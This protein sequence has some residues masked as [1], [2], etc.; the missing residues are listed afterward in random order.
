MKFINIHTIPKGSILTESTQIPISFNYDS[1]MANFPTELEIA[2]SAFDSEE[3]IFKTVYRY[4]SEEDRYYLGEEKEV[5]DSRDDLNP[6][7][8]MSIDEILDS[9]SAESSQLQESEEKTDEDLESQKE[10]EIP[11][12]GAQF[13]LLVV[14]PKQPVG[15]YNLKFSFENKKK[16]IGQQ[17]I[18]FFF[19]TE[20][21]SVG[22]LDLY[23]LVAYPGGDA[24]AVADIV[25]D[26]PQTTFVRVSLAG[27]VIAEGTAKEVGSMIR[28]S[29]PKEE[30]LYPLL[31]E[32][33]PFAPPSIEEPFE[34]VS[35]YSL[36]ADVFVSSSQVPLAGELKDEGNYLLLHHFRG[37]LN[38][39]ASGKLEQN[40]L[41]EGMP[42]FDTVNGFL[43]YRFGKGAG[44]RYDR[45]NLP[46][47]NGMLMPFSLHLT[48]YFEKENLNSFFQASNDRFYFQ[49][50]KNQYSLPE[51]RFEYDGKTYLSSLSPKLGIEDFSFRPLTLS[52]YQEAGN[53]HLLWYKGGQL[54]FR[55]TFPVEIKDIPDTG[56]SF[57]GNHE[58]FGDIIDEFG[59]YYRNAYGEPSIDDQIFQN[60]L[61]NELRGKLIFAEG[62]DS[63]ALKNYPYDFKGSV[64]PAGSRLQLNANASLA[65]PLKS[66]FTSPLNFSFDCLAT[67]G[68][69][70]KITVSVKNN[71]EAEKIILDFSQA[72]LKV[73]DEILASSRLDGV[74][75]F[76]IK[77]KD[78][79]VIL[80]VAGQ[81][82]VLSEDFLSEDLVITVENGASKNPFY[83]NGIVVD[84]LV[85]D[86]PII[87]Y[88]KEILYHELF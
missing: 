27:E 16:I 18:P 55:E 32:T 3:P 70:A 64:I 76:T 46:V 88:R 19:A 1:Q 9:D 62:F 42:F 82:A 51:A 33:F 56:R 37:E 67:K 35:P 87:D 52:F 80:S 41:I 81:E 8:F 45:L 60:E 39:F 13:D 36:T 15:Y 40:S 83:L 85:S 86:K 57:I 65:I 84:T 63:L 23:P 30:D 71:D 61:A 78:E 34:Y 6:E 53:S 69:S 48:T 26:L 17:T 12:K 68:G 47:K 5:Y 2:M 38:D 74:A 75:R 49:L 24:L 29:A 73:G 77:P 79:K 11:K 7:L 25:T 59:I 58:T 22:S 4:E 31:I 66:K 14:L 50:G 72:Q 20:R 43:G 10:K 44:I 54:L 21:A 28:F